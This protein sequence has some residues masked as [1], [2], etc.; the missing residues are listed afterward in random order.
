MKLSASKHRYAVKKKPTD[1]ID[2]V[3][4]LY[5]VEELD[6]GGLSKRFFV[7]LTHTQATRKSVQQGIARWCENN[8]QKL[9]PDGETVPSLDL[10]NVEWLVDRR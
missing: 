1:A 3:W 4:V 7:R 5:E 6:S 8:P 2:P 10:D 9:P